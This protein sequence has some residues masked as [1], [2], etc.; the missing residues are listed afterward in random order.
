LAAAEVAAGQAKEDVAMRRLSI[1][2]SVVVVVLVGS[3]VSGRI[4][5]G[6]VAQEATPAAGALVPENLGHGLPTAAPGFDLSLYRVTFGAGAV[7]P[8]HTHPGASVVYVESGTLGFTSLEGE[9]WLMP[10]GTTADP[11]AQGELLAHDTEVTLE[12]GDSLFFPDEHG[13]SA[14]NAGDGPLVLWL[15]NLH[16]E[17][18]PVLT[19]MDMAT[20]MP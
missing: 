18:E 14:Y 9:A 11:E 5:P 4:T 15:A 13:D 1:L 19:L 3:L 6:T 10:A 8:P 20:P 12:A 7:L 2:V 17:G 16:T